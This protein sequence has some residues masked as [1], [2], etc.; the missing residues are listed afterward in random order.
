MQGFSQVPGIDYFNTYT[1]VAKLTSI[2]T[3]LALATHLDLELHQ[4]DIKG[5]YLNGKLNDDETIYMHQ[6]PG[7]AN[8]ALPHHVCCLC[9]TLYRLK[10]SSRRWYQKLVEILVKNLRFKLCEVD[11]AVFIKQS[12][13]TLIIIIVHIDDCTIA[14]STPS[15]IIELKVQIRNH[16]EIT[17][18]G[19]LHWLLGIK[20][21]RKR[22]EQTIALSQ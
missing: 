6:P 2:R 14:T 20:V 5:A 11:Q 8:P 10:Q 16:V 9:K 12:E 18:L 22:E 21:T 1:P 7:Y 3:V 17:D 13:K 19:E 15:L 4:I